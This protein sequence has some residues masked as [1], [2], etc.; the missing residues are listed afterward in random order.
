[1]AAFDQPL[2]DASCAR[3][4]PRLRWWRRPRKR[5]LLYPAWHYLVLFPVLAVAACAPQ[6]MPAGPSNGPPALLDG[7]AVMGDGAALPLRSWEPDG[8]PRAVIVALHGFNMHAGLFVV[9]QCHLNR[10]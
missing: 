4:R 8:R 7:R 2:P 10:R 1:M 6:F 5:S 3:A 9:A